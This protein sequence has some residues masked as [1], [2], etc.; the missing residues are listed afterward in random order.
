MREE[1]DMTVVGCLR[2]FALTLAYGFQ[3]VEIP[4]LGMSVA[5]WE[6]PFPAPSP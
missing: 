6:H 1:L 3:T 2:S 5:G 4:N